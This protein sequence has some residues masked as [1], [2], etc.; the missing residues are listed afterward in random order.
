MNSEVQLKCIANIESFWGVFWVD[1][2]SHHT[3]ERA[4]QTIGCM[5][6]IEED[7]EQIQTWLSICEEPWL[8]IVDNVDDPSRDISRYLPI[9]NRGT[10]LVTTR[11]SD[12][13]IQA[14][15]G[16]HEVGRMSYDDAITLLLRTA[17]I[18]EPLKASRKVAGLIVK[19][20]GFLALAITQ[21]GAY[22]QQKKCTLP[23]YYDEYS[24]Q[25]QQLPD[26]QSIQAGQD[27]AFTVHMTGEIAISMIR[28]MVSESAEDALRFLQ[29]CSFWHWDGI[30]ESILEA[31]YR[32][33]KQLY[34]PLRFKQLISILSSFSF[35]STD[36]ISGHISMHPMVHAWARD[37]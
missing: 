8:L 35:M 18:K 7:I 20:L 24:R 17:A 23:E 15:V 33:N 22:I 27:H 31:G 29:V 19:T 3:L 36:Q 12:C 10:V 30:T 34:D 1:A 13:Q 26:Y 9:G 28:D 11:N 14:T 16:T 25:R 5:C 32:F 2:S 21:A 37:R 6:G 4:Y